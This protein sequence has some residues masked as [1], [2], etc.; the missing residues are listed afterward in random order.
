LWTLVLRVRPED[1]VYIKAGVHY[2]GGTI[3]LSLTGKNEQGGQTLH[4]L[5]T[6]VSLRGHE[7]TIP[8]TFSK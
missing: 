4:F 6:V 7:V 5:V 2:G 1:N 8:L 3:I